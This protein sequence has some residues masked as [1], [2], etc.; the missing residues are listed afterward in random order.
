MK[1]YKEGASQG[2]ARDAMEE[3]SAARDSGGY[4]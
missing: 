2:P 4:R 3:A 1:A